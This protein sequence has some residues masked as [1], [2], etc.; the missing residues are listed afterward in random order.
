MAILVG[1]AECAMLLTSPVFR[2]FESIPRT[3]G[4]EEV[5]R[6]H[7][8]AS[9]PLRWYRPP[10]KT[11]SYVLLVDDLDADGFVHWLV[12]DIPGNVTE[13]EENASGFSMPAAAVELYN[14]WG[15]TNYGGM[16][17]PYESTHLYRFRLY[18][19]SV[20]H[21]DVISPPADSGIRLTADMINEQLV[22]DEH[23]LYVAVLAGHYTI[24]PEPPPN[25]PP[26]ELFKR[27]QLDP[28]TVLRYVKPSETLRNSRKHYGPRPYGI[29]PYNATEFCERQKGQDSKYAQVCNTIRVEKIESGGYE[30]AVEAHAAE[31]TRAV[32]EDKLQ[33]ELMPKG[34]ISTEYFNRERL[35]SSAKWTL[36]S[37]GIPIPPSEDPWKIGPDGVPVPPEAMARARAASLVAAKISTEDAAESLIQWECSGTAS[38]LV[39]RSPVF[40]SCD[41]GREVTAALPSEFSC[42]R[43]DSRGMANLLQ[44][45]APNDKVTSLPLQWKVSENL[46]GI[47]SFVVMLEQVSTH[48][49]FWVV[50][51]IP[52]DH[53]S[54]VM[55]ASHSSI[56]YATEL[57]NYFEDS[58]YTGP[59]SFDK[60]DVSHRFRIHL[61][62]LNTPSS[63]QIDPVSSDGSLVSSVLR[64]VSV[65]HTSI[66]VIV[67]N[68][69]Q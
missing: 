16:C 25:T 69:K 11:R 20:L 9:P 18:A 52:A 49:T 22:K 14:T 33:N 60:E 64:Q 26:P 48:R 39:L 43:Q 32:A 6:D 67:D 31:E 42:D 5:L 17:P 40:D 30:E 13:L 59:C 12:K 36:G 41:N 38:N 8:A 61:F 37:D 45:K 54:V 44:R 55:G 21:S 23:T 27:K 35:E 62:A 1:V 57:P 2:N 19:R 68:D 53:R 47:Q 50:R 7:S 66:D 10:A 56:N 63:S 24:G 58:G 28:M 4:C 29:Y 15:E 51:D 34:G 46:K 3:Y 65:A